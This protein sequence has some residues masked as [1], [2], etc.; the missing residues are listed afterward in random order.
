MRTIIVAYYDVSMFR[1]KGFDKLLQE[2]I[3][4]EIFVDRENDGASNTYIYNAAGTPN[5]LRRVKRFLKLRGIP[6]EVIQ[7]DTP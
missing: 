1:K 6:Y 4:R 2:G 7:I 5:L 3:S